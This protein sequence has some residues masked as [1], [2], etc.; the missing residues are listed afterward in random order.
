MA[1]AAESSAKADDAFEKT[2][3]IALDGDA[4]LPPA[5]FAQTMRYA[6][7]WDWI[8]TILGA[9]HACGVARAGL[10]KPYVRIPPSPAR[11]R[12]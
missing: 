11:T 3:A 9:W 5:T 8:C 10:A 12:R 7:K 2:A 6:D 1:E 4:A